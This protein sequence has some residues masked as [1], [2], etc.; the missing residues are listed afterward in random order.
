M[1]DTLDTSELEELLTSS[2]SG[3]QHAFAR[4]YKI[5]APY[6]NALVLRVVGQ[7]AVAQEVLQEAYIQIWQQISR[8]DPARGAPMAWLTNIVRSRALDR[9]RHEKSLNT[10]VE[11]VSAEPMLSVVED[12]S[13][14]SRF[15]S[16]FEKLARCLQPISVEQRRS[17]V[18]AFCYGLSHSELSD[19]INAPIGTVK[20]W[21]RRGLTSVRRCMES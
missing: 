8:F 10:R 7:P 18:L 21:I 9:V 16:E 13:Q 1:T 14:H 5:T 19:T 4:L 6:L 12:A 15:S 3:D 20:S 11:K 2:A 17:I